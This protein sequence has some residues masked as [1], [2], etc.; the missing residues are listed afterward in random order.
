[1]AASAA[2]CPFCQ[3][4]QLVTQNNLAYAVYDKHPVTPGHAL[5]VPYRHVANYFDTT[6]AEKL[7]L[8]SMI[9]T[10]KTILD[11]KFQPAGYNIGVNIGAAAGQTIMHVHIH[12]IPRYHGDMER[13]TGGV[14]GVIPKKQSY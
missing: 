9:D 3:P 6:Q 10:M 14:R 2:A 13:P 1:M 5:I 8:L 7:T 4:A 12:L 11:A